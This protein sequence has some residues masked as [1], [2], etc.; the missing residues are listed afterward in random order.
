MQ[1]TYIFIK[2]KKPI[3]SY[4]KIIMGNYF[5]WILNRILFTDLH[6]EMHMN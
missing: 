5:A 6:L 3:A 4:H 2:L 1:F